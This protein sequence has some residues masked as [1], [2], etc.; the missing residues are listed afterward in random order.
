MGHTPHLYINKT[1][2]TW[3]SYNTQQNTATH[4][5]T[6]FRSHA[7]SPCKHTLQHTA[8]RCNTPLRSHTSS[9]YKWTLQ[10]TSTRCNTLQHTATHL[11][12]AAL[13]HPTIRVLW[14]HL[15]DMT[16]SYVWHDSFIWVTRRIQ[17]NDIT[18][19]H[20][21]TWLIQIGDTTLSSECS[22]RTYAPWHF[23][24]MCDMAHSDCVTWLTQILWHDSCIHDKACIYTKKF[25]SVLVCMCMYM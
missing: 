22:M 13:N 3:S 6:P 1:P 14:A 17:V 8:T 15:C 12:K 19:P 5:T 16:H 23:F 9:S 7:W 21:V 25:V 11:F 2:A 10:N 4:C 24:E 20:S 18:H